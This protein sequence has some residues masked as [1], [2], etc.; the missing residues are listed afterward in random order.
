[1]KSLRLRPLGHPRRRA[2]AGVAAVEGALVLLVFLF[3]LFGILDLGFLV[4]H[5]NMLAQA[6]RHLAREASVHGSRAA[7]RKPMWGPSTLQGTAGDSTEYAKF[8][9]RDLVTLTP[10]DVR[11]KI[12]YP[13]GTNKSDDRVRITLDYQYQPIVPFV[14]GKGGIN[15]RAVTT[16]HV[17]H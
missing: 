12:E 8:L 14:L 5:D 17:H 11:F 10:N 16:M 1:M 15:L 13:D 9:K 6:A 2:R 7:P 3:I 4:L